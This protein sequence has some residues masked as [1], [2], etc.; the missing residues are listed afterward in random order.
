MP[1]D[2]PSADLA[3]ERG[4]L[5]AAFES[6]KATQMPSHSTF[7]HT[8]NAPHMPPSVLSLAADGLSAQPRLQDGNVVWFK[9]MNHT[10]LKQL[11]EAYLNTARARAWRWTWPAFCSK[12]TA[13]ETHNR[14]TDW[15][16]RTKS[17]MS[18]SSV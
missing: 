11:V 7:R 8:G 1:R 16:G 2:Q 9:M 4:A 13:F 15:K 18:S 12:A 17:S 10:K 3:A 6:S 5:L 14:P